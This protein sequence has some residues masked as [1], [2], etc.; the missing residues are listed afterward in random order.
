MTQLLWVNIIMDTLAGL[1][2]AGEA[3]LQRY[4][5]EKP[6]RR[7]E[8]LITADMWSAILL[9]GLMVA[10]LSLLFLT[11]DWTHNLFP[12]GDLNAEARATK[13]ATAF[14]TFF[15]F[16]HIFNTF[17]ARTQG[18][19]LLEHLFDNRLFPVIIPGIIVIQAFFITFG[20]EVL[21]TVGLS[22][23]EWLTVLLM[24]IV[25]IPIDLLR[26][27]ARNRW[28]GNPVMAEGAE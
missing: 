10:F 28:F 17:N 18:L 11:S 8:P 25:I 6:L 12:G 16:L 4:M 9:N 14:F 13:F 27:A 19:N 1:A 22:I 21:R 23:S 3:A 5:R 7:D 2:F 15:A 26:K 20:G 24:A